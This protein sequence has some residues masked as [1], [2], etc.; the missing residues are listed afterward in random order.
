MPP[1]RSP[2]PP[3]KQRKKSFL[4]KF[5]KRKSAE[6]GSHGSDPDPA[7]VRTVPVFRDTYVALVPSYALEARLYKPSNDWYSMDSDIILKV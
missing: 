6:A 2:I 7:E 5:R 1:P 3:E 4:S